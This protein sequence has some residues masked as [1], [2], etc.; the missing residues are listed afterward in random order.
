[1]KK[2]YSCGAPLALGERAMQPHDLADAGVFK[3]AGQKLV[4]P[5]RLD[6]RGLAN[7]SNGE[8]GI[9]R[10]ALGFGND[11][12]HAFTVHYGAFYVKHYRAPLFRA[13]ALVW[14]A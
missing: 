4:I 11:I 6:V 2:R 8:I 9:P 14:F 1:M 3:L 7:F 12:G 10:E 5:A 13:S